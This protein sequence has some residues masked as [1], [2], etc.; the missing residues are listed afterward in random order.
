MA[1][2][3][4]LSKAGLEVYNTSAPAKRINL[5]DSNNAKSKFT[6][7]NGD[8]TYVNY[9]GEL[10]SDSYESDYSDISSN[11]TIVL[12]M[13]YYNLFFKGKK[14]ALKKGLQ[15]NTLKWEEMD[16]PVLGFVT[17]LSY[18]TDKINVKIQ[19]MDALLNQEAKFSFKKT[20]ISKIVKEIIK[21]SGLKAKVDATG[22]KDHVIDFTS[23]S[24]SKK[25]SSGESSDLKLSNTELDKVVQDIIGS[26]TDDYKKLKKIHEWGRKNIIYSTYEC[27]N[28]GCDPV[29]AYKNRSHLN[30]GDTAVLLNAMY[31][32]AGLDSYIIHGDYHFWNIVT[33]NGKKY[34]SDG[35]GDRPLGEVWSGNGHH[36]TPF[37]GSKANEKAIC[38]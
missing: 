1:V 30:C 22:L 14:A 28:Y 25:E 32:I 23:S 13:D 6:L 9:I 15:T 16:T 19:G 34:A 18:T 31:K 35:T 17:E 20:K 36:N 37:G 10:Y 7:Q 8:T 5:S 27:S 11:A 12:P 21:A 4:S 26:E 38:G 2:E 3:F 29:K 24:S 33:I